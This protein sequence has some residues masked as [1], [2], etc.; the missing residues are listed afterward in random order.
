MT[1]YLCVDWS[2]NNS[3]T[4]APMTWAQAA[5]IVGKRVGIPVSEADID[6]E[7]IG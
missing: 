6:I 5:K 3:G 2:D 4:P 7:C 1:G